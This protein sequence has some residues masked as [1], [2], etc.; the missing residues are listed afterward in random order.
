MMSCAAQRVLQD[1][2][3]C[4]YLKDCALHCD[5]HACQLRDVQE[6]DESAASHGDMVAH[7]RLKHDCS[8]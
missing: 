3:S 7:Q 6:H 2:A 4:C 8:K 1:H 5:A